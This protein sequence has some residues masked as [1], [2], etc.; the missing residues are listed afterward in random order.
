MIID[1][2]GTVLTPGNQGKDCLGNGS[3]KGIECCCDAC[4]YFLCCFGDSKT[5][6]C[7]DCR[8][9]DCPNAFHSSPEDL[10]RK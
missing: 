2:T 10:R 3:H 6:A 9:T 8:D 5:E 1:I 7:T 4:N